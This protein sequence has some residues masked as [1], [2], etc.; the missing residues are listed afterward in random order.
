MASPQIVWL[1]RD[2]R[3]ADQPALHTAAKA[4]PVVPVFVLD[5]ERPRGDD[6]RTYGGAHRWW[7][8]HSLES[9]ATGFGRH[10]ARIVLRKGDSVSVL[11]SLAD[12][13]G[14]GAIHANRH[15]EPWWR[16]AEEDLRDALPEG[17]ELCLHDGNYLMPPGTAT[18]G[19]GDPYKIYTPFYRSMLE[20]MPPRDE[21]PVPPTISQPSDL[22]ESDDLSDWNLLP[23]SPNWATRMEDFWK[24][25]EDAAHDRLK[26]WTEHVGEYEDGR[27]L[28]SVDQTSQLS[29][30][31]H[32]GE[33][34]PVTI[35]HAL[36]DKRS[37]GWKTYESELIWRDYAQNIIYQFPDYPR[38]TYRDA[39]DD[40]KLWRNPNRGHIIQEELEAW[41]QG[42]TGYPIVD[43]G[44]RQLWALGWMHNRVRM[45][46]ASF[47]I[48]HLL[49][50]WRHGERWFWD[51]L[52]DGDYGSNATNWQ[53]VAGTGVDSNMFPR[54]MAPLKQS[55]KFD[56]AGY[57]RE[58]VPELADLSDD[59]IHD[60]SD[61]CRPDDYPEK[62]I[63]H[64]EGRERALQAYRDM[65][66]D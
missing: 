50:D 44:M 33:I 42:R 24:V 55:D 38:E 52:V 23:T 35:W 30:H 39:I 31:L 34:S 61:Q 9:L 5:D 29:P 45:I 40:N 59:E 36:K 49:I 46:A 17:C 19:S 7:L 21:L 22:P 12:Q 28:P 8:H 2:L 64:K 11:A 13:L 47:L 20:I 26:W 56:A 37:E 3:L 25:G 60:P 1:R 18:T 66:D 62:I 51:T 41:Q 4:G 27:N 15:Y 43:A 14:A 48:K 6:D 10:N 32:W 65:K 63:S 53:W 54:I 16:E 58:W 57:I